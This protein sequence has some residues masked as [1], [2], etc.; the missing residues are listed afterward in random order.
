VPGTESDPEARQRLLVT[1][2]TWE[3]MAR[4]EEEHPGALT[5]SAKKPAAVFVRGGLLASH[6]EETAVMPTSCHSTNAD[7]VGAVA[8]SYDCAPPQRPSHAT[9]PAAGGIVQATLSGTC[10]A[11]GMDVPFCLPSTRHELFGS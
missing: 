8:R 10:V 3:R 6:R 11:A 1:A 2:D 4:W 7:H 5:L 9:K